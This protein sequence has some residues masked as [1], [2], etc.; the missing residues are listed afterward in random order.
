MSPV[1]LRP[2]SVSTSFKSIP[3]QNQANNIGTFRL[4]HGSDVAP[5]INNTKD[6]RDRLHV[7]LEPQLSPSSLHSGLQLAE[8]IRRIKQNFVPNFKNTDDNSL[9]RIMQ[10]SDIPTTTEEDSKGANVFD[11]FG[12]LLKDELS[13]RKS[14]VDHL[15]IIIAPTVLSGE[16]NVPAWV[17]NSITERFK[18]PFMSVLHDSYTSQTSEFTS[19]SESLDVNSNQQRL[20]VKDNN[21]Y[22][23]Q[24]DLEKI[25]DSFFKENVRK[26]P[27][28][29][30]LYPV[31]RGIMINIG[32]EIQKKNISSEEDKLGKLFVM[33]WLDLEICDHIKLS[34][35]RWLVEKL[36]KYEDKKSIDNS[37]E[38]TRLSKNVIKKRQFLQ[39]TLRKR[40]RFYESFIRRMENKKNKKRR[41]PNFRQN[42][43][44][45]R[46]HFSKNRYSG[47]SSSTSSDDSLEERD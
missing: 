11:S 38:T 17:T 23:R 45:S 41:N 3:S 5:S 15:D 37:R 9:I 21:I 31:Y 19:Q 43:S 22:G 16:R 44:D 4:R 36:K 1:N 32:K 39:R 26:M 33:L 42:E 10:N 20:N 34:K 35:T 12:I 40:Y 14:V 28:S 46:G 30:K 25:L 47:D 13:E 29:V 8:A 7:D 6:V 2:K 18:H 24:D 27:C